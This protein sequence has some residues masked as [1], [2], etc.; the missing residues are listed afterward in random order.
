MASSEQQKPFKYQKPLKWKSFKS[1]KNICLP[2]LKPLRKADLKPEMEN[3]RHGCMRNSMFCNHLIL[4]PELGRTRRICNILP[5]SDFVYGMQNCYED[6]VAETIGQW[7]IHPYTDSL[8]KKPCNFLNLNAKAVQAGFVTPAEYHSFRLGYHQIKA[9]KKNKPPLE[10][11][12]KKQYSDESVTMADLIQQK[13]KNQW[14]QKRIKKDSIRYKD[15]V[16][17]T[18]REGYY[19]TCGTK[20]KQY[21][22]QVKLSPPWRLAQF[23]KA[24]ACLNT[25]SDEAIHQKSLKNFREEAPV[26]CGTLSLG[27]Y[28]SAF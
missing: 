8:K 10:H 17:I 3:Y 26:R 27:I 14:L 23:Q 7:R 2:P 25:F 18:P 28:T 13:F 24:E 12:P 11:L 20:I 15:F 5:G 9:I 4:K 6:G 22:S 19:Q 21:Q 16:K 1:I